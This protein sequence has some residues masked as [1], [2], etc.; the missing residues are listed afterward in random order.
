MTIFT[1][2]DAI[3][4][5]GISRARLYYLEETKKIP[6]AR[7]TSTGKRYFLPQDL[8]A[9]KKKLRNHKQGGHYGRK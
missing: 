5:L 1:V 4:S 7:R 3:R 9:I 6:V 8:V 2:V